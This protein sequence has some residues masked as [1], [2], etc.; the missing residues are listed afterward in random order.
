MKTSLFLILLFLFPVIH[1]QKRQTYNPLSNNFDLIFTSN[2]D[3]F[4]NDTTLHI[5]DA[6]NGNYLDVKI[7]PFANGLFD[8]YWENSTYTAGLWF[9]AY[10]NEFTWFNYT[11]SISV[12]DNPATDN[13]ALFQVLLDD[14]DLN[15]YLG[16]DYF[17]AKNDSITLQADQDEFYIS[18]TGTGE[19]IFRSRKQ[20]PGSLT[21]GAPTDAE[22]D[23]IILTTPASFGKGIFTI[24]DTTGTKLLYKIESDG[25]DWYYIAMSKAL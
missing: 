7:S 9:Y 16:N 23:A 4:I 8:Y 1:A 11:G 3:N 18:K 10:P 15:L 13:D 2:A 12:N 19:I 22:I 20:L 24:K 6:I 25:T 17:Q 14:G 21:D 5:E